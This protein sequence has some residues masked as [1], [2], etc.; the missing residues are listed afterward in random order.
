MPHIPPTYFLLR[1]ARN[2]SFNM[3]VFLSYVQE[4]LNTSYQRLR[5]C[6]I[7]CK[8]PLQSS[9]DLWGPIYMSYLLHL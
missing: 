4:G 6:M 9:L 8:R 2:S 1:I 7:E 3:L 5:R